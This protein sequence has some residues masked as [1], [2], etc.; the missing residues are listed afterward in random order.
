M[1]RWAYLALTEFY[2]PGHL[3]V[4]TTDP[5]L[6]KAVVS[7]VQRYV[8]AEITVRHR[9]HFRYELSRLKDKDSACLVGLIAWLCSGGWEPYAVSSKLLGGGSSGYYTRETH[10]F[11]KELDESGDA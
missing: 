11:R 7:W 1:K 10:H 4:T 9:W 2:H 5:E 6:A 8:G 3:T